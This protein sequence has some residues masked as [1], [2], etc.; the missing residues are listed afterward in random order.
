MN[1]TDIT[2]TAVGLLFTLAQALAFAFLRDM[3]SQSR[4]TNTKVTTQGETLSRAAASAETNAR[5]LGD[6]REK[7]YAMNADI[8]KLV[9]ARELALEIVRAFD[10]RED[11][12]RAARRRGDAGT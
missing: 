11:R 6:V 8:N 10:E 12:R 9:G 4:D 1:S 2:V 7:L 5:D 3:R